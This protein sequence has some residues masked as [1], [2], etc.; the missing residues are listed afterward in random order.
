MIPVAA[1]KALHVPC[2]PVIEEPRI[3]ELRLAPLPHIKG[4]IH[5]QETHFIGKL[6]GFRRK[7]IV[8]K[9]NRIDA[10]LLLNFKLPAQ[11]I[12]PESCPQCSL[13]RMLAGAVQ[14]H[15]PPVQEKAM[16]RI[17][18][19]LPEADP[20]I[21]GLKRLSGSPVQTH[22]EAVP[23][24]LF[25]V[26]GADAGIR[27]EVKNP[28]ERSLLPVFPVLHFPCALPAVSVSRGKMKRSQRLFFRHLSG[29]DFTLP[30]VIEPDLRLRSRLLGGPQ[31]SCLHAKI[32][33]AVPGLFGVRI[34]SAVRD[35]HLFGLQQPHIAVDSGAGVPARI[36]IL[37]RDAHHQF[38]VPVLKVPGQFQRKP[39][40]AVF[41]LADFR[42]VQIHG[43]VH[44]DAVE[45]K[46]SPFSFFLP[47]GKYLPVPAGSVPVEVPAV[48]DQPVVR[49]P[50]RKETPGLFRLSC[51][52]QAGSHRHFQKCPVVVK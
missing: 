20:E 36:R 29:K 8:R 27:S 13:I 7:R 37:E 49:D 14:L 47:N 11:R 35:A 18:G 17:K 16:I 15:V 4:F 21:F 22:F 45:N 1:D 46:K 28:A 50:H 5:D 52:L 25:D 23:V 2:L 48:S 26:P 40:V 9:A 32:P 41:P 24:R 6:Q 19:G 34:D 3:V 12:R 42:A 51:F 44:V 43:T 31:N 33:A 10:H 38:I 39:G 30:V